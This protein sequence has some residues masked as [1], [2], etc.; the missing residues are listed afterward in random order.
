MIQTK[1]RIQNFILFFTE[2]I[3]LIISFYAAGIIW[4][5]GYKHFS[6]SF[7]FNELN[8]N[9]LSVLVSYLLLIVIDTGAEN[10]TSRGYFVELKEVIKKYILFA[11]I[12]AIYELLRR[13]EELFPRGVYV[14]MFVL[15]IV[16]VYI[17]RLIIKRVLINHNKSGNAIRLIAITTKER[18]ERN[19][20]LREDTADWMRRLDSFAIVDQDMAGQE[21]GGIPVVASAETVM[22]Y[23]RRGVADEVYIDIGY[24]SVEHL[25]PMIL[26]LEDM[27]V[28]VHI[29]IDIMDAFSDFDVAFGKL[30]DSVVATFAHRLYAYKKLF[31]KRCAD[32]VGSII[33]II[34]MSI[35]MIFVAPAIKLDSPGPIFF[36]QK[37]VGKGGRFFYIYKFRS[38]YV[39]AEERKREL[40]AENEMQ[41]LMFKVTDDTRI[42]KVGKFLRKTSIDELPQFINVLKGDMS[43]VGTR[44]PTID[45]FKQYAGHHK[46]RLT[47]KPGIT[48]MWQAYGRNTVTDFEDVVKMDLQ[49]ID[50]WSLSLD[51]KILFKTVFTVLKETGR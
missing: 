40:A 15:V 18:A 4:L 49:Y 13:K 1:E 35:C 5:I 29:K 24:D 17:C 42:T 48:G 2:L 51:I 3:C 25:R 8:G 44:P 26:E 9:I 22:T 23:I 41:G 38:M 16:S 19:S 10:F 11:C 21:I 28:T 46:R 12:I 33:G 45:E 34:I 43:L 30:G 37:R 36:K 32:I 39:D 6:Y 31:I 14:I 7:A 27:G 20:S 47:M 50:N